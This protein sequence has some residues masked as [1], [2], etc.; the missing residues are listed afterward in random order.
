MTCLALGE[1]RGSGRL[2]LF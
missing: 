2:F 1:T